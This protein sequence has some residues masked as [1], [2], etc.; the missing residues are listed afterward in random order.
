MK[1]GEGQIDPTQKKLPSKSPDLIGLRENPD[2]KKSYLFKC[3]PVISL[4][5]VIDNR[6]ALIPFLLVYFFC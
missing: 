1:R 3:F 5:F 6:E 2:E 4:E